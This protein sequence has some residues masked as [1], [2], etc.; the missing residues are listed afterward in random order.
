[1]I[2]TKH[3][4]KL[5]NKYPHSFYSPLFFVSVLIASRSQS[6]KLSHLL[7]L[8]NYKVF[9]FFLLQSLNLMLSVLKNL[10]SCFKYALQLFL[11]RKVLE[12]AMRHLYDV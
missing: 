2:Y 3:H 7:V 10:H 5:I 1:M 9:H 11:W 12:K 4:L 8:A 6:F